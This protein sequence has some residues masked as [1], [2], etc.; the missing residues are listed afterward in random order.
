M[1]TKVPTKQIIPQIKGNKYKK[2]S[3]IATLVVNI[4]I[5]SKDCPENQ[6]KNWEIIN[7]IEPTNPSNLKSKYFLKFIK[8]PTQEFFIYINIQIV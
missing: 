8:F 1:I 7:N 3:S 5:V 2:E 6:D 4:Y